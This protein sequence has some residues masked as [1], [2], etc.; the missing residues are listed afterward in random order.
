[1]QRA[2]PTAATALLL[3]L[4]VVAALRAR[5]RGRYGTVQVPRD[6]Q[7]ELVFGSLAS[8]YTV[9]APLKAGEKKTSCRNS[10]TEL[11]EVI[12]PLEPTAHW[13]FSRFAADPIG[14]VFSV[15]PEL[16]YRP[17]VAFPRLYTTEQALAMTLGAPAVN[18]T[19]MPAMFSAEAESLTASVKVCEL[20]DPDG[21]V[22]ESAVGEPPV[23]VHDPTVTQLEETPYSDA[24]K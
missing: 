6:T 20:P 23:T 9:L 12:I 17:M 5:G 19:D 18:S 8:R 4:E 16:S 22:T 1:M 24:N 7:P 3:S 11:P 21:G 13:L 14:F 2:Q 10:D 15:V